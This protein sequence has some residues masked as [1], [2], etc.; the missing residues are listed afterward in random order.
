MIRN[1]ILPGFN[2]DPSI[3]RV[4]DDYYI[5]TS[6]FE[7]FPGVQ[8]HHSRDLVNW[9]LITRPLDRVSQ[10]NMPGNPDS[11][12]I[13]AP[14]LSHRDGMFWLIYTD[15]K[16]W[17]GQRYKITHNYLATAPSITGPWSEPTH[18][19][20]SGFDASLFHDDD[21]R[22]WYLSMIWDHRVEKNQ[23]AGTLLQEFDPQTRRL[24]GPRRNIF[25][26]TDLKLTEGPHLYKRDGWY[27]LLVAE[28]GTWYTHAATMARSRTIDGPY[29]VDPQN[30]FLTS[31]HAPDAPLQKAGHAS[32]VETQKG[33]WYV[34][35]LCGRPLKDRR[36]ILG[37][38]TAVQK[39]VWSADGWP[40][41]A[42][43]SNVPAVEVTDPGLPA[44]P[45]RPR[46]HREE[47]NEA[48]PGIHFQALRRPI[49]NDW[50]DL[51]SRP[52]WLRLRGEEPTT[53][54]FR[55]SLLARRVQAFHV[56]ASTCVDFAPV[57]FKHMAGLI[58][59]YDTR[60]HYY[61]RISRDEKLGR[62]L[63]IIKCDSGSIGE[64][65]DTETA[66][67]DE[68]PVRLK[69]AINREAL[70]FSFSLDGV[71]WQDIGPRLDSTILSDDYFTLGFTGAF[72]G[73]CCQDLTGQR[74]HAD[75]DWFEYREI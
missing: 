25:R 61:L 68:D 21:G 58:A 66:L 15:V 49:T 70:Q 53:S 18:L 50:A 2:P 24:V 75:F 14:C 23:F 7:W 67:P 51:T 40:R 10:L 54:T 55:Q 47:F 22:K 46:S 36:C 32:L 48:K 17:T 59:Y 72:V 13:W 62:H 69:V 33:D 31:T 29:E 73:I 11:G 42:H 63:G 35:H 43:G 52:G 74:H 8:I 26:G 65:L 56:E 1:P 16:L 44:T 71:A 20:S 37:R 6:T 60:L 30:P 41:L 57:D 28:G 38:E 3:V 39:M 27:Y 4:G 12:G 5:A 19:D 34:V 9:E 45:A 64:M